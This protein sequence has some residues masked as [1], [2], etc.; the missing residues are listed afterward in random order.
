LHQTSV[1][2]LRFL[3]EALGAEPDRVLAG[4]RV[5]RANRLAAERTDQAAP[6]PFGLSATY[7]I[8]RHQ[9]RSQASRSG[10]CSRR[11]RCCASTL[12]IRCR[13]R[14]IEG[15]LAAWISARSKR[16]RS[17]SSVT[18]SKVLSLVRKIAVSGSVE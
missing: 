10:A 17:P 16:R 2:L 6:L 7:R 8:R 11:R 5:H 15:A 18:S 12:R 14:S 3:E 9:G 13:A 1:S 4:G